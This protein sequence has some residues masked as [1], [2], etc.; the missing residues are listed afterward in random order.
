MHAMTATI[1]AIVSLG[2]LGCSEPAPPPAE[3]FVLTFAA[4]SDPGQPLAGVA[5]TLDGEAVGETDAHGILRVQ[6]GGRE[7]EYVQVQVQCPEGHRDAEPVPPVALRRFERVAD[8]A[9]D[10]GVR[11]SVDCPPTTRLAAVLVRADGQAGLPVR[12]GGREVARTDASGAASVVLRGSPQSTFRVELDTSSN[13]R[14][15]PRDPMH[16]VTLADADDV[17]VFDPHLVE[18]RRRARRVRRE[19]EPEPA[20]ESEPEP[21]R[22]ERLN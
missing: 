10:E 11:V 6:H 13:P 17:F 12:V 16:L 4:S 1:A 14:L 7:G 20:V 22:I 18:E 2:A 21:R 3:P 19:P 15:R 5:V 8:T 9:Q